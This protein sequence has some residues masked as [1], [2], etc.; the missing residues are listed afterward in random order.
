MIAQPGSCDLLVRNARVFTL[1]AARRIHAP[2]ALA[3]SG[4]RI[5]AVGPE[6]EVV[7]AYRAPRG[8][9]PR[10]A[11]CTRGSSTPTFT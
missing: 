10:G 6:R 9:T 1:D 7:G 8:S 2:G 3:I 5:V 11:P 4:D